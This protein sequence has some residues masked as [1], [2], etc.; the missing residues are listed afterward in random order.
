MMLISLVCLILAL[1][2]TQTKFSSTGSVNNGNYRSYKTDGSTLHSISGGWEEQGW[3][4]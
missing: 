1:C 3:G 4:Y 2:F